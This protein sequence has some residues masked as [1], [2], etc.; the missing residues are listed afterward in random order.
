M[1]NES[2]ED[3]TWFWREWFYN[4]WPLDLAIQSVSYKNNDYKNGVDIT[5]VN[6]QKMAMPATVE[7]VLKDGS[8]QS[9]QLPVETWI[10]SGVHTIHIPLAQSLQSVTIDPASMLP[11]NNRENNTWKE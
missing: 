4:N 6:L 2:G 9:F 10:Q 11:D 5:I 7:I 1:D 8:K 3:L